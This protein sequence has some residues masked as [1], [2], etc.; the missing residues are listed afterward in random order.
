LKQNK[1]TIKERQKTGVTLGEKTAQKRTQKWAV[2]I[3]PG[4][5]VGGEKQG[6]TENCRRNERSDVQRELNQK[7]RGRRLMSGRV[8]KTH[9]K[10][11][12]KRRQKTTAKGNPLIGIETKM[13]G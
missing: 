4:G 12:R 2:I 6:G 9:E 8:P 11:L 3:I 7:K 13:V 5:G 10:E 1:I